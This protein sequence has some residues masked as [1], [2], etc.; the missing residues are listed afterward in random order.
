MSKL[1]DAADSFSVNCTDA[2]SIWLIWFL[3]NS[4]FGDKSI[5]DH[6][7]LPLL[8]EFWLLLL[9]AFL[10]SMSLAYNLSINGTCFV[11]AL[12]ACSLASNCSIQLNNI[13]STLLTVD[14]LQ[15]FC[16]PHWE[17]GFALSFHIHLFVLQCFRLHCWTHWMQRSVLATSFQHC[18]FLLF[19]VVYTMFILYN[20]CVWFASTHLSM[21][22]CIFRMQNCKL[23]I[24]FCSADIFFN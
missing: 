10:S 3:V 12:T 5:I 22:S 4:I 13:L 21:W 8:V 20:I 6:C 15:Q 16:H 18:C 19:A 11:T 17:S 2:F 24:T 14:L 7:D 1:C 23:L 9:R